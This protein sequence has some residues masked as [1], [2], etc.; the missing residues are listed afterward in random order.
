MLMASTIIYIIRRSHFY[1]I[2]KIFG[3]ETNEI[4]KKYNV[5]FISGI[6]IW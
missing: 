4:D 2:I 5:N 6:F 1:V 3:K